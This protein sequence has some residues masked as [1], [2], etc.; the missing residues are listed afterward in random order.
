MNIFKILNSGDGV[1]NEPRDADIG[2]ILGLGFPIHT[3]GVM[4]YIDYVGAQE[5][6]NYA[7]VLAEKYGDRF[8]L[9]DSLLDRIEKAGSNRVFYKN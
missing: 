5:F 7:A 9:P 4:S 2:S 1:L 6:K 3:G 8:R